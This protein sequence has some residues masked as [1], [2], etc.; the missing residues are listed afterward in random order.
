[1]NDQV[2]KVF[3]PQVSVGEQITIDSPNLIWYNC[4][5]YSVNSIDVQFF[6]Q[7]KRTLNI[8]DTSGIAIELFLDKPMNQ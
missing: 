3:S 1:M 6:D 7:E 5:S 4:S 8:V 2:L